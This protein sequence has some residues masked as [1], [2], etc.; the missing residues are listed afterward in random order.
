[1][2]CDFKINKQVGVRKKSLLCKGNRSSRMYTT[3]PCLAA[4]QASSGVLAKAYRT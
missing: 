1:M 2:K 3:P 4:A